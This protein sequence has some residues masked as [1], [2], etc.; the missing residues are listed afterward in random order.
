MPNE[1]KERSFEKTCAHGVTWM[2]VA[3]SLLCLTDETLSGHA[4]NVL[5]L[6]YVLLTIF[7]FGMF[8]NTRISMRSF[9]VGTAAVLGG[10]IGLILLPGMGRDNSGSA[11]RDLL[12]GCSLKMRR[13]FPYS[14]ACR[15][16]LGV[17]SLRN[18]HSL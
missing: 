18:C 7:G 14:A 10:L 5:T 13:A 6:V 16:R 15:R 11:G 1:A 12:G 17:H 2:A 8:L 3:V 9:W 4:L